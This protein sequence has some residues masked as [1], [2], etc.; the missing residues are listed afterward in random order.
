MK[1]VR[2]VRRTISDNV[3]IYTMWYKILQIPDFHLLTVFKISRVKNRSQL[4]RCMFFHQMNPQQ[5]FQWNWMFWFRALVKF[6]MLFE[7]ESRLQ[8][9][10]Q[11]KT[12]TCNFRPESENVDAPPEWDLSSQPINLLKVFIFFLS[13]FLDKTISIFSKNYFYFCCML[14]QIELRFAF[15]QLLYIFKV[16]IRSKNYRYFMF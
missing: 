5:Q 3:T 8:Q 16:C 11:T 10:Q 15:S 1:L 9:R 12:L 4:V 13:F 6:Q 2:R 14:L 7:I